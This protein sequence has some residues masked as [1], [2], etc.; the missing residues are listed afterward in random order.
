MAWLATVI[1]RLRILVSFAAPRVLPFALLHGVQF[2][3]LRPI[4]ITVRGLPALELGFASAILQLSY[5][6]SCPAVWIVVVLF[7]SS[8]IQL[9]VDIDG[10]FNKLFQ[11]ADNSS[12]AYEF[13]LYAFLKSSSIY[14]T[15]G[16]SLL[17]NHVR[18]FLE[19]RSILGS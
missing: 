19:S 9:V 12:V 14:G 16:V 17:Y 13:V 8:F 3:W 1:A 2:H 11:V 4:G 6:G 18:V 7:Y 15:K 5:I 10:G